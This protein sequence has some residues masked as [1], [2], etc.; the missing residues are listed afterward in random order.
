MIKATSNVAEIIVRLQNKRARIHSQ[1]VEMRHR[2]ADIGAD[3]A[4]EG[5]SG[6]EYPGVNDVAVSQE[7]RGKETV[8][9]ATGRAAMFIEFGTGIRNAPYPGELPA[10]VVPHGMYGDKKGSNPKGWI[11][12]GEPGTGVVEEV[13][14]RAGSVRP[15][16]YRTYG[17]PPAAA[18][19]NATNDME[20]QI[21][22]IAK[23]VFGK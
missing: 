1:G 4:R 19:L 18:M 8:V 6:A 15:G 10:G 5:F 23:E 22:Q 12:N 3:T 17:N 2:L 14:S 11:Y 13:V 21:P 7:D 20:Q 16:V 9:A